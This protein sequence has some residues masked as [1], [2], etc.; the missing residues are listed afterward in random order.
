VTWIWINGMFG[1]GKT[2]VARELVAL[3][4]T[5]RVFDPEHVGFMLREHLHGTALGD[6][7]E[8]AAWR[9]LT[10]IVAH[11][12][13]QFTEQN[14]VIVQTV[15]DETY[16]RDLRNGWLAQGYSVRMVL[17]EAELE[18][19]TDRIR[20][21]E[22]EQG[23]LEW[24]LAHILCYPAARDWLTEAADLLIDTTG[25]T[26]QQTAAHIREAARGW[27]DCPHLG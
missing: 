2:S 3:D 20:T 5:M 26:P 11:E 16:W 22:V 10:P 7:Q 21:D 12:V 1:A 17:L 6:F 19:L 8:L 4:P 13:A 24:R 18:T 14:L 9:R 25:L 27:E 15:L 23:A